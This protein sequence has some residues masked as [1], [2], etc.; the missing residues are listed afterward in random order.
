MRYRC[1]TSSTLSVLEDISLWVDKKLPQALDQTTR[2]HILLVTQEV[3][4][5][6]I[7]H[8]NESLEYKKVSLILTIE[9]RH[10]I[11]SVRD[12]GDILE[13][14]TLPSKEEAKE[15]NYLEENGR[16]LKLIVLLSDAVEIYQSEITIHFKL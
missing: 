16:G 4:S 13:R 11:L 5:N 8:G 3:V 10:I 2:N 7:I 15:M 9:K 14:V 1:S 6:A 12:E